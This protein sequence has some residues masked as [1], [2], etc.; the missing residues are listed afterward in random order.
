M[1]VED[2]DSLLRSFVVSDPSSAHERH[3]LL[4]QRHSLLS[5]LTDSL[6]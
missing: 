1:H 6:G 2:V 3:Q 5:Q 4:A